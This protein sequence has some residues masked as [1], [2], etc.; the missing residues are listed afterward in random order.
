[1]LPGFPASTLPRLLDLDLP[2]L[3][4]LDLC[5][6]LDQ[7]R[8]LDLD[9]DLGLD[10]DRDLDCSLHGEGEREFLIQEAIYE[11]KT[12]IDATITKQQASQ[13]CG[14]HNIK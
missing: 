9:L 5:L 12:E 1:M 10:L 11:M 7:E 6:G 4:D 8:D 14:A 3:C 2:R 13:K